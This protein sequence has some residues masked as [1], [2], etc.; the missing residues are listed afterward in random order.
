MPLAALCL[1]LT[2]FGA[3]ATGLGKGIFSFALFAAMQEPRWEQLP[4]LMLATG[5]GSAIF[6]LLKRLLPRRTAYSMLPQGKRIYL[7]E[8]AARLRALTQSDHGRAGGWVSAWLGRQPLRLL[9]RTARI[10]ESQHYALLTRRLL[11]SYRMDL[12]LRLLSRSLATA[13]ALSDVLW[14]KAVLTL[15]ER[16]ADRIR[17]TGDCRS[18]S[19]ASRP[20]PKRALA[21][22]GRCR[23]PAPSGRRRCSAATPA[24]AALRHEGRASPGPL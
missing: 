7:Q 16:A 22:D 10:E 13:D 23:Q 4:S 1:S 8:L 21:A 2:R 14:E 11:I 17:T 3:G 24:G 20:P 9:L 15:N 5:L 18:R 19:C 12:S 6:L